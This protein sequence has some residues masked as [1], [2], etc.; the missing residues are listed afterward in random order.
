MPHAPRD[1]PPASVKSTEPAPKPKE[2]SPKPKLSLFEAIGAAWGPYKELVPFVKPYKWRFIMGLLCGAGFGIVSGLLALVVKHVTEKVFGAGGA[3]AA[4]PSITKMFHHAP[5]TVAPVVNTVPLDAILWTCALIPGVMIVR[6]TFGYLNAYCVGWVSL[7]ILHDLRNKLFA[8]LM[9]QS[10]DFYNRS[11]TGKLIARVVNDARIAQGALTQISS[12]IVTQ[13]ITIIAALS[14]LFYIDWQF[15]LVSFFLFPVC[16]IPI[17]VFGRRVRRIGA[18]EEEGAGNLMTVLQEAFAGVRVVKSLGREA[19]EVRDFEIAG[20][21]QFQNAI[22]VRKAMEIVG[23][24]IEAIAAVG[25]GLALFYVWYKGVSAPALISMLLGLFMLYDPV[26]KLSKVHLQIQ[27]ALSA[28]ERIFALMHL[29]PTVADAP[30]A[31]VLGRVTGAIEL[32]DV[33]FAYRPNLPSAVE[34][35]QLNIEPGKTYALV[36]A[37]G[38]GKST[39]LSLILRFYDPQ[40][41]AVTVDGHDIREVTQLSLRQNIA[42]VSQD[43]FLF[44]TTIMENIRYGRLD[45]SDEE[46][47]EA[48]EQA[49]AHDFICEQPLGYQTI[50]GDKGCNLSGGQ[51]QRLAIARALLRN[52]PILLLDEATSALDSESEQKIQIALERLSAGRTVIAIAHRLSTIVNADQ[53]VAMQNGHI[54]EVGTHAE[55][56][57]NRGHYRRL[58]DLQFKTE[59]AE[60]EKV[61]AALYQS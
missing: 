5:E 6:S 38:S 28:T 9:D 58:Y 57:E 52:A 18:N 17:S 60:Q 46:V 53:I 31:K 59:T 50:V 55:L 32:R 56:F 15:A 8:R 14:V 4:T 24:M 44:H 54:M 47:R 30:G 42:I 36:G 21:E 3:A 26:K 49:F 1:E 51:Q 10:M 11:Q 2:K 23:P 33:T 29:H 7:R 43:T 39:L 41:G 61:Q 37:S 27:K 45:A 12:D 40:S 48:A 34:G 13:P 16:L 22:R 25:I 19:H 20:R 35:I